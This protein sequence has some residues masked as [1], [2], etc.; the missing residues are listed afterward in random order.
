MLYSRL[1]YLKSELAH[2]LLLATV[3]EYI[4]SMYDIYLTSLSWVKLLFHLSQKYIF[5]LVWKVQVWE[6]HQAKNPVRGLVQEEMKVMYLTGTQ[7]TYAHN[8]FML[9]LGRSEILILFFCSHSFVSL[10]LWFRMLLCWKP[11]FFFI[12]SCL[13]VL[14]VLC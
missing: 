9:I 14:Q 2:W 7:N 13:K 1:V 3:S 12:F 8:N 10:D 4:N 5:M 6:Y 11:N